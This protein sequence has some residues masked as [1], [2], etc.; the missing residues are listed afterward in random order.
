MVA[1]EA[2]E[3]ADRAQRPDRAHQPQVQ[4]RILE[5]EEALGGGLRGWS[6]ADLLEL[7]AHQ[8]AEVG[9]VGEV[10]LAPEQETA[11]LLL[12]L[13]DGAGQG[14]LGDVALLGRAGEV[15]GLAHRE[16]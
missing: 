14:R 2:V 10:P 6:A 4:G 13:L 12:E 5:L 7:R 8:P 3:E 11:E 9:Q 1:P 16:K 15:E